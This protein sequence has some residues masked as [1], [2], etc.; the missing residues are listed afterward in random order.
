MIAFYNLKQK[1]YDFN[2]G[3]AK[4]VQYLHTTPKSS[5]PHNNNVSLFNYKFQGYRIDKDTV[6]QQS[7][8]HTCNRNTTK[9]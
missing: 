2:Y 7:E 4:V 3:T 1:H 9:L 8:S 5:M 6:T